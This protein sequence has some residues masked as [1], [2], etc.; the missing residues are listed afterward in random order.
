MTLVELE[1]EPLDMPGMVGVEQDLF[2]L[3]AVAPSLLE[4]LPTIFEDAVRESLAYMLGRIESK[5]VLA[6]FSPDQLVDRS[7]VFG[8][9]VSLYNS[10][11][12]P[13]QK[14]IDWAFQKRVHQLV[15]QLP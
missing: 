2:T 3:N 14:G 15:N 6:S 8:R 9:L 12:S 10:R 13:L 1:N 11:A 5:C 4:Q 7:E